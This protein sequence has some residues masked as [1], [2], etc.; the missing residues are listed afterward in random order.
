MRKLAL[1]AV[2]ALAV[3][4]AACGGVENEPNLAAAAERAEE[5]GSFAFEVTTR[6]TDGESFSGTCEGVVDNVRELARATCDSD[7]D[8]A[9]DS[10]EAI[11]VGDTSH[12]RDRGQR[13]WTKQSAK[14][15]AVAGNSLD[16]FSP[17]QILELLRAASLETERVGEEDVRGEPTVRYALTVD[18]E[19]AEL[20]DCKGETAVVGVWIDD[21][22]L[23]RRIRL[24]HRFTANLEFFD[25]GVAVEVEAPPADQV[26]D[27]PSPAP[28]E[29]QPCAAVEAEPT[30]VE[31][32]VV[33]LGRNG[34][35]P[36]VVE[37]GCLEPPLAAFISAERPGAYLSC[38]V[39]MTPDSEFPTMPPSPLREARTRTAAN[40]KCS[41]YGPEVPRDALSAFDAIFDELERE[42]RE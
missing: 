37:G 22:E 17:K 11:I 42:L 2:T 26:I 9:F 31:Q 34:Y 24:D 16:A 35:G 29:T 27:E 3:A 4:G 25:F 41:L 21:D 36:R 13:K 38:Q 6:T 8:S 28:L 14:Q 39:V 23:V 18:C 15:S 19:R 12:R 1:G 30:R 40:V 5:A 10:Y 7:A 32:V 20:F 33:A